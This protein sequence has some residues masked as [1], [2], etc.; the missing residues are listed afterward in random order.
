MTTVTMVTMATMKISNFAPQIHIFGNSAMFHGALA[1]ISAFIFVH[2]H[3]CYQTG[4]GACEI[5]T[6]IQSQSSN[7]CN[8]CMISSVWAQIFPEFTCNYRSHPSSLIDHG[9]KYKNEHNSVSHS[10]RE[11]GRRLGK[12]FDFHYKFWLLWLPWQ[13]LPWKQP[14]RI[15]DVKAWHPI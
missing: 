5:L 6:N 13:P 8:F 7:F 12:M 10:P 2:L 1:D 15:A 9:W 11:H 4:W 14:L 3:M